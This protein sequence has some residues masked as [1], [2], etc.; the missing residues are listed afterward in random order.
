[1]K[2]SFVFILNI[3]NIEGEL[4]IEVAPRHFFQKADAEQIDKIKKM[5]DIFVP[6]GF[7][8]ILNIRPYE[9]DIIKVPGEKPSSFS[10]K[11][12]P[13]PEDKWRYWVILFEGTNKEL[14]DIES[15]A[16]LLK[17]DIELG[18][19]IFGKNS[20]SSGEGYGWHTPSLFSFFDSPSSNE[21]A[22]LVSTNEI[23]E[24]PENYHL[25]KKISLDHEHIT[26]AFR[27]L[28]D[29]KSLPRLSE[30]VTTGY[31]SIIE[32]LVTH[33]PNLTES[34]DSLKHQIRTKIPLLSKRFQRKIDYN[35]YFNESNEET[36]WKKLYDYRS[37]IVHGEHA[38]FIGSLQILKDAK[39]VREFLYETV[40]LLLLLALREPI[41]LTDLKKC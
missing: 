3:I 10:F 16:F 4:P 41:F 33:N 29:L 22:V 18:F 32:S 28:R 27:K 6:F 9:V 1:M 34:S 25:I 26:R 30:L 12:E 17:H 19:T 35:E 24:I 5:L 23:R 8:K 7:L 11:Y 14:Q 39:T 21:P 37:C 38:N 2:N 31:F 36:I 15:A 13:L 20:L 40:K